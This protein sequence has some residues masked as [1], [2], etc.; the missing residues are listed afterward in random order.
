MPDYVCSFSNK[1][2]IFKN[3]DTKFTPPLSFLIYNHQTADT[4]T[5]FNSG[6]EAAQ[7]P[8]NERPRNWLY[9]FKN[10]TALLFVCFPFVAFIAIK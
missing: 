5:I 7:S 9:I 6:M 3:H 8:F 4:V 2:Q 1:L 10:Y